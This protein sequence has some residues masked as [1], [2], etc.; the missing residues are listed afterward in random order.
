MTDRRSLSSAEN[1][2]IT[3]MGAWFPGERVVYRGKDLF[4][5]L[6]HLSW[7]QLYLYGITGKIFTDEQGKL[8]EAMWILSTSFPDPRLW[9]NRTG[10]LTGNMRSTGA[11]AFGAAIVVS[12]ANIYGGLPI[13]RAIDFLTR[14]KSKMDQGTK[15]QAIVEEELDKYRVI[16]G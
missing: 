5:E 4:H 14:S 8:F 9:N 16:S 10:S 12:E 1:H 15:L 3:Y 2:W 13:I 7:M 6:K 11:L